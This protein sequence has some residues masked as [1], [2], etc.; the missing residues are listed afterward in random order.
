MKKFNL[1]FYILLFMLLMGFASYSFGQLNF[2]VNS[3]ADDSLSYPWDNPD[4]PDIDESTDGICKDE[5]GRCTLAAA[6]GEA[7][8]MNST[9]NL[10]FNVEGTINLR[11]GIYLSPG[12]TID[13][14][15]K[16]TLHSNTE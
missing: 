5:A 4:T 9:V 7:A 11:Y 3:L 16:I 12:S 15:R 2:T 13:G 10:T 1:H 14:D 6:I 8:N